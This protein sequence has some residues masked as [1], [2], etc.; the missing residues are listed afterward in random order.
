MTL[1]DKLIKNK[2][3]LILSCLLVIFIAFDITIPEPLASIVDSIIG[4]IVVVGGALAIITANKFVGILALIASY[5]LIVRSSN[6][7]NNLPHDRY[8]PSENKK[9]NKLND[10]NVIPY[11]TTL[12]EQTV[13]NMMPRTATDTLFDESTFRPVQNDLHGAVKCN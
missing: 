12:E 11:P 5:V 7:S 10:M 4:K 8:L 3:H 6:A 1:V 9:T 13:N 2:H